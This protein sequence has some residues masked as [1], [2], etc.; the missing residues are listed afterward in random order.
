MAAATRPSRG[1]WHPCSPHRGEP[2]SV[3]PSRKSS[4]LHAVVA[5]ILPLQDAYLFLEVVHRLLLSFERGQIPV[6]L[7]RPPP[8]QLTAGSSARV[9]SR[10]APKC[11][12]SCGR[13]PDYGAPWKRPGHEGRSSWDGGASTAASSIP[14]S[15]L[16]AAA[17]AAAAAA[18]DAAVPWETPPGSASIQNPKPLV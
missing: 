18:H 16:A 7:R 5:L 15:A 12:A 2:L 1:S 9:P 11:A 14:A 17:A 6:D 3:E 10:H 13:Y 8:A 4:P